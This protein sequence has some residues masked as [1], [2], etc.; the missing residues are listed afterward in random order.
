MTSTKTVTEK[1]ASGFFTKFSKLRALAAAALA[2][3][4]AAF[5]PATPAMSAA[6]AA[7][8]RIW[9]PTET[10]NG[11]E[12]ISKAGTGANIP[13]PN[14][15]ANTALADDVDTDDPNAVDV[16]VVYGNNLRDQVGDDGA[17]AGANLRVE[18]ANLAYERSEINGTL[19][20]ADCRYVDYNDTAT[21]DI[22]LDF[23]TK[24]GEVNAPGITGA[25]DQVHDWRD[26]V[27]A[28]LV[29]YM[30][31][32]NDGSA[33]GLAH[34]LDTMAGRPAA[35]FSV[36]AFDNGEH[37]FAHE[38]GHNMGGMHDWGTV[39]NPG[40]GQG[41]PNGA[42]FPYAFGYILENGSGTIMSYAGTRIQNFSNPNITVGGYV[43]G[44]PE[45]QAQPADNA[46][47]FNQTIP[48]VAKY[49]A[50]KP[51]LPTPVITPASGNYSDEITVTI[52]KPEAREDGSALPKDCVMRYTT[53]G[54]DVD[55]SKKSKVYTQP[56][57]VQFPSTVKAR[58]FAS[59]S[60]PSLQAVAIYNIVYP[61]TVAPVTFS[62]EPGTGAG[63]NGAFP[64]MVKV[65]LSC[66]TPDA[67]IRYTTDG[68]DVTESSNEYSHVIT[69]RAAVTTINARAYK[70]KHN[71]VPQT[72]A[73]YNVV[74]VPMVDTPL[75]RVDGATPTGEAHSGPAFISFTPKG[76]DNQPTAFQTGDAVY[77]STNGTE[78]PEDADE[79]YAANPDGDIRL[80]TPVSTPVTITRT[81]TIRARLFRT[82]F[83]PSEQRETRIEIT[84][85]ALPAPVVTPQ[86]G[87]YTNA[88]RVILTDI[89]A[90]G[91]FGDNCYG[92]DAYGRDIG[93]QVVLRYTTD[94]SSVTVTSP[95]YTGPFSLIRSGSV[96]VRAYHVDFM[97]S[98]EVAVAFTVNDAETLRAQYGSKTSGGEAHSL[99][100]NAKGELRAAGWNLYGQLGTGDTASVLTPVLVARGVSIVDA[101]RDHSLIVTT[102]GK[103]YAAGRNDYGQLGDGTVENRSA[104]V[105]VA[106]R[107]LIAA[108]GGFHTLYTT[109]DGELYATGRNNYGQ[110]GDGTVADRRSPVKIADYVVAAAAGAFHSFYIT[111]EGRL[112][113][114]G[115]NDS[116][117]LGNGNIAN[118]RVPI[119]ITTGLNSLDDATG[120]ALGRIA[121]VA[122]G[123][124]HTLILTEDGRLYVAGSNAKGQLGLGKTAAEL[125]RSATPVLVD[126]GVVA[127]AAGGAHSLYI[128]K[129]GELPG[130][131]PEEPARPKLELRGFGSNEY[132]QLG[133]NPIAADPSTLVFTAPRVIVGATTVNASGEEELTGVIA[134]SAGTNHTIYTRQDDNTNVALGLNNYGQLGDGTK[135][136]NSGGATV[137]GEQPITAPK[138]SPAGG[139]FEGQVYVTL[140]GA[141]P[142]ATIRYTTDGSVVTAEHGT[143]YASPFPLNAAGSGSISYTVNARAFLGI[144]TPSDQVTA[145]FTVL[146][147][148]AG[149]G[150]NITKQPE[151]TTVNVGS[152]ASFSVMATGSPTPTFQWYFDGRAVP[153]ATLSTYTI[154]AVTS[155]NAG[156]YHVVVSCSYPDA[157]GQLATH[158]VT[159]STV[160]LVLRGA[161]VITKQPIGGT[162]YEGGDIAL[163]VT[164]SSIASDG[165]AVPV[166]YQ[167]RRNGVAIPGA[168][169]PTYT[170]ANARVTQGG[171]FD[172][173]VSNAA[174]STVS[175]T[176]VVS[177][178]TQANSAPAILRQP[179]APAVVYTGQKLTLTV[180]VSSP[181]NR[182]L[183][184]QWFRGDTAIAGA[185]ASTLVFNSLAESDAGSYRVAV[186]NNGAA[187]LDDASDAVSEPVTLLVQASAG[188]TVIKGLSPKTDVGGGKPY[189]LAVEAVGTPAPTYQ[190]YF[191]GVE[192]RGATSAEYTIERVTLA[193]LGAYSVVIT[194]GGN[195]VTSGP[196]QL[197]VVPEPKIT[198]APLGEVLDNGKGVQLRVEVDAGRFVPQV[199]WFLNGV[200]IAGA[201]GLTLLANTAGE[202]SVRVSNGAGSVTAQVASVR[203]AAAPQITSFTASKET[204]VSGENV[205]FTVAATGSATSVAGGALAYTWLLDGTPIYGAPNTPTY[206]TAVSA[207]GTYSVRVSNTLGTTQSIGLVVTVS[208][209]GPSITSHPLNLELT[210]GATG[211]LTVGVSGTPPFTYQWYR[212]GTPLI[213]ATSSTYVLRNVSV[214]DAGS[215]VVKISNAA[216]DDYAVESRPAEVR[217]SAAG[218]AAASALPVASALPAATG[219][220]ATPTAVTRSGTFVLAGAESEVTAAGIAP[221]ILP[222]GTKIYLDGTLS[223][224][225]R[226]TTAAAGSLN[227]ATVGAKTVSDDAAVLEIVSAGKLANGE[228][229]YTRTGA[230]TA[231]FAYSVTYGDASFVRVE[232]GV[233]ELTFST[234]DD[235]SYALSGTFDTFS[236]KGTLTQGDVEGQGIFQ[237]EK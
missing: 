237:V 119:E 109:Y 153:G 122:A 43:T 55:E 21:L 138:I 114:F 197:Y 181:D 213:G 89:A 45:G 48:V 229:S 84:P 113:A 194:S 161:P 160:E 120:A 226:K 64:N 28:D 57:V 77:Y 134:V 22:D 124:A 164:A 117:Q 14:P 211:Y 176:A 121:N 33:G 65:T 173:L 204:V 151:K 123:D 106:E 37:T 219:A 34:Y 19:R 233:L 67:K 189:T 133:V 236:A 60:R 228:Y 103:L 10:E 208:A 185:T 202:Y 83:R 224:T 129:T 58:L 184:Y 102:D 16:L 97:P 227:A 141:D 74:A 61:D 212:N 149:S 127:I 163:E 145:K 51:G 71:L 26:E 3:A 193:S 30:R 234:A 170:L 66:A 93:A 155:E 13:M 36:I 63:V 95:Q 76:L 235:G 23:L 196:T 6:D 152:S 7:G 105:L 94:G 175:A 4:T 187:S 59:G 46:R 135:T 90:A 178:V 72:S 80:F 17:K 216:G 210:E 154:P 53:D 192:I 200:E 8:D 50:F 174:G 112:Y 75:V 168:N 179:S 182:P 132:G 232:S 5:A 85:I 188:I 140:S 108:A 2:A 68:S 41:D 32:T 11:T 38:L 82:N 62:P 171:N 198:S 27:G 54:S 180:G 156:S 158:T 190:W 230:G 143:I 169:S 18:Y 130:V 183:T 107:V 69:L 96:K 20:L 111:G 44:V 162:V 49:R 35:G 70:A 24:K 78:V 166:T 126:T 101:T 99:F 128:K 87:L 137:P 91:E 40:L 220:A 73:T 1:A 100:V 115:R 201:T 92:R 29:C 118:Q 139:T 209:I 125:V 12:W 199:Q 186:A 218:L 52:T 98:D 25:L 231:L 86:G 207:T 104:P 157:S 47:T 39:T 191:N 203:S 88:V 165:A 217:V 206:T 136:N 195:K 146:P 205:T 116:G 147:A 144:R 56:F 142:E 223:E 79:V 150:P 222:A 9:T 131:V 31:R 215:Y 148:P 172:V 15:S 225:V 81:A 110:L 159:S 42:I 221:L 167:W 177:V 214:I